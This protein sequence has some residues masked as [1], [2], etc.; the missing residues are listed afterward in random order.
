MKYKIYILILFL[1]ILLTACSARTP[2]GSCMRACES[3]H[4]CSYRSTDCS[5]NVECSN[6]FKE[7]QITCW[8]ACY[9]DIITDE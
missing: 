2:E 3:S 9:G 1:V 8:K 6:E 5:E 4:G 7:C